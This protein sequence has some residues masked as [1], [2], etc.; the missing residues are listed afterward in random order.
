[1]RYRNQYNIGWGR[2]YLRRTDRDHFKY[3]LPNINATQR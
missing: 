3:K 2:K 1:M